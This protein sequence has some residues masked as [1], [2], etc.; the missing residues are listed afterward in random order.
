MNVVDKLRFGSDYK[1]TTVRGSGSYY[2]NGKITIDVS[3]LEEIMAWIGYSDNES[4]EEANNLVMRC[5][6]EL[7]KQAV[8]SM[9]PSDLQ[10]MR[11]NS[12]FFEKKDED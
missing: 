1:C 8:H 7:D 2:L 5:N 6:M 12:P 10:W 9:A 3:L 11:E 4:V